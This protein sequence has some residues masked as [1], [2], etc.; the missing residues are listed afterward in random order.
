MDHSIS[1]EKLRHYGFSNQ[2]LEL[3]KNYLRNKIQ[4]V[5]F[6]GVKSDKKSVICG[7]PQGSVLGPLLFLLYIN[8]L[9]NT[10]KMFD[11]IMFA[12]DITLHSN[13]KNFTDNSNFSTSELIENEIEKISDWFNSNKLILNASKSKLITFHRPHCKVPALK[14]TINDSV[15]EQVTD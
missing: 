12:D 4:Y 15:I 7:V 1:I 2:A 5:E 6:N 8:D 10:S 9:P 3:I 11:T 14:L 13:F